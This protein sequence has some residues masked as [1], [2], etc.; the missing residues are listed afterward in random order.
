M[1]VVKKRK[2]FTKLA[3]QHGADIGRTDHSTLE[4]EYVAWIE[5]V[6]KLVNRDRSHYT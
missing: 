4:Y 2:G 3:L 6:D 1:L 5:T